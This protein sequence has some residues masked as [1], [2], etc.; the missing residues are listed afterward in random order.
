VKHD[1]RDRIQCSTGIHDASF[2]GSVESLKIMIEA[3]REDDNL[4]GVITCD[5]FGLT[6]IHIAAAQN[7]LECLQILLAVYSK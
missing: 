4:H 1:S 5:Q 3:Y 7:K 6:P 2:S